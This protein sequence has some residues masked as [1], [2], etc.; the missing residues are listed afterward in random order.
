MK[1]DCGILHYGVL[2]S[3]E[4]KRIYLPVFLLLTIILI[5]ACADAARETNSPDIGV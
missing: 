1:R 3:I 2:R 4:S 5:S